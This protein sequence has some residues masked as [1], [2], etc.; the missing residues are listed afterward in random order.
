MIPTIK[1][2]LPGLLALGLT[3]CFPAAADPVGAAKESM[4][5]YQTA[6]AATTSVAQPGQALELTRDN[7]VFSAPPRGSYQNEIAAYQP[8]VEFLSKTLGRKVVFQYA[9]N[10]LSY[11]KEMTAGRYDM[12]FDG[13]AFNG[14]RIDKL[15][16]TPLVKLPEDFVFVVVVKADNN[17]IKQIKDLAGQKVCAHA[18]PNLGTLTLQAQFDNPVRQPYI[19]E[20][21]GWDNSYKALVSGQCAATILPI[22][23]LTKNEKGSNQATRVIYRHKPMPNQAFSVGPR[24]A[25]GLHEKI[26]KALLSD[27]GRQATEKLRAAYAGK[28]F[29]PASRVE[30]SGLGDLLKTSLYYQ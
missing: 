6:N 17:R 1:I 21:K 30:Y 29:V 25:P 5:G 11:S 24:I 28:D 7:L 16:H 8:L 20:V 15:G 4:V 2:Y 19:T 18:P 22:E 27:E 12:V 3:F 26:A 23:N 10:W 13:P 9:D 14:W